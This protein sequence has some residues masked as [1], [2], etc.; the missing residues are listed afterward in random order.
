MKVIC[1]LILFFSMNAWSTD[2]LQLIFD[3]NEIKQGALVNAR[4]LVPGESLNFPV[5]KLKG[6]N[7]AETIYFQ[8]L[9]PLMRKDG[10]SAYE[11]D[12]VVM[13]TGV[14]QAPMVSGK[15]GNNEFQLEWNSIKVIPIEATGKMLWADFTAPDFFE[16]NWLKL[17]WAILI[18]PI[19]LLGF[20][21]W[22]KISA[23]KREKKRKSQLAEEIRGCRTYE[24]VVN[25]WKRKHVYLKEFPQL[26][27]AFH[28]FENVFFKYSFKATQTEREKEEVVSAYRKLLED[29]QG[30]L[31]GI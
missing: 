2:R 1:W 18:F 16:Q 29:S 25:L 24:D 31:S 7:V 4:M 28:T 20:Y 26:E 9:S 22:R 17:L 13:F 8:K 6:E 27:S 10:S 23:R 21:A 30:G 19:A 14:P 15:V 5:Q 12:V 11:S 3:G